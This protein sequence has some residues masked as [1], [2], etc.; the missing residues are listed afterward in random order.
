MERV[1]QQE[2][3]AQLLRHETLGDQVTLLKR[4]GKDVKV[5]RQPTMGG[6]MFLAPSAKQLLAEKEADLNALEKT[7]DEKGP[8]AFGS[9]A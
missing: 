5:Y 8:L 1:E 6:P 9:E 7:L 2:L 4:T 3:L